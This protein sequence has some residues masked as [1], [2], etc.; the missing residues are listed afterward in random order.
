MDKQDKAVLK[1][2]ADAGRKEDSLLAH[3]ARG[4]IVLPLDLAKDPEIL[5]LLEQKF[6]AAK[7]NMNQYVVGHRDNSINPETGLPEFLSLKSF[8]GT[9]IGAALG[10]FIPGV[11]VALGAKIGA[12]VD[13]IRYAADTASQAREQAQQAQAA[14]IAEAQKAREQ[15]TA[16]AQ[17]AREL[18]VLEAQKARELTLQQM[19]DAR[20]ANTAALDQQ[21]ADAAARLQQAKMSAE[22][23]AALM[24]NLSAQQ[25][26]AAEAARATLAQQQK[27][28]AE[29]K[30]MME[31][32]AAE[33]A[34]A[35]D[36]ERRKIAE[37]ESAQMTARR[38]AGRRALLS[39]ARLTPETGI[40]GNQYGNEAVLTG[41]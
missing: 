30:A 21:K 28:Y 3:V 25:A 12:S 7:M 16:E 32:Q 36:A 5:A 35:L 19:A 26:A 6:K 23:Q 18:A 22:Q 40:T 41:A 15:A 9:I 8:A 10:Y 34:A 33:Q 17:K 37:R 38:R 1:D 13:T 39:S 14:A 4:E 29:Q 27:Q 24:Q 2:A 20:A 31:K 11:G